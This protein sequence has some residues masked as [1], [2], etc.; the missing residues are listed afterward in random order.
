MLL[1]KVL[2]VAYPVLIPSQVDL[3]DYLF[4]MLL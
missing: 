2:A 3:A 4:G 1:P